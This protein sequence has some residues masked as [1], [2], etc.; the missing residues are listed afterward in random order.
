MNRSKL[1]VGV[2]FALILAGGITLILRQH[3]AI[4]H[5]RAQCTE[6]EEKLA[7]LVREQTGNFRAAP[8]AMDL[9]QTEDDRAELIR[10]RGQVAGLRRNAQDRET[11][12]SELAQLRTQLQSASAAKSEQGGQ[13]LAEGLAPA[14]S[15]RNAGFN[16]PAE[17]YETLHWALNYGQAQVFMKAFVL[18][19]EAKAKADALFAT[20]PESLRKKYSSAEELMAALLINTTPVAGMRIV[21]QTATSP[22]ETKLKVQYQ[23]A[24][25]RVRED[26]VD[27]HRDSDGWRQII[28]AGVVDKMGR[29]LHEILAGQSQAR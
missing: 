13:I 7:G 3:Q 28:E 26:T 11:A 8:G 17:A 14:L 29:N 6:L 15:W 19:G 12:R 9:K 18:D 4:A 2:F 16:S 1:K 22:D 25:G 24:D 20:I 23:Y 5:L 21:E 10:L 27:F